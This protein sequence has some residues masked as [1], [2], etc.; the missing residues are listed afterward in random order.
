MPSTSQSVARAFEIFE[1]FK[2]EKRALSSSDLCLKTSVPKSTMVALLK[3]LTDLKMVSLDRKTSTYF[4]T[5]NFSEL[6]RW[7]AASRLYPQHL[8]DTLED[9]AVKTRET[10][11]LAAYQD[12]EL[13]LVHVL[14]SPNAISFS[15]QKGQ[16]FP[17][18]G[19]ALGYAYLSSLTDTRI[20]NL[21]RRSIDRKI[22][23]SE[24]L[25]I[26]QAMH[27]VQLVRKNKVAI[28]D[29]AVFSDATAISINTGLENNGR[30]LL[31]AIAGPTSR[32]RPQ[33]THLTQSLTKAVISLQSQ[34][35]YF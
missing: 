18:W 34:P 25:P 6:G 31:I 14:K 11:T 29:G 2:N 9:L 30:A 8:M 19:T 21:Y 17:L 35:L 1:V 26:K 10:I 7:L 24:I 13:E 3:T 23:D 20:R 32:L 12:M 16:R 15:A 28:A 22:I 4:P 5:A 27:E 33:L